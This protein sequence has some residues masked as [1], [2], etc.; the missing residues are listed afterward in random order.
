MKSPKINHREWLNIVFNYD[1]KRKG[2]LVGK[3]SLEEFYLEFADAI[4][5]DDLASLVPATACKSRDPDMNNVP[6]KLWD[7][8][9]SEVW[10]LLSRVINQQHIIKRSNSLSASEEVAKEYTVVLI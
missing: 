4:V 1:Q 6:L 8:R 9:F 5:F 10:F 3:I 7:Y 2:C